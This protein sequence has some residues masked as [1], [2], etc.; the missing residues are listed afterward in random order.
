MAR[1]ALALSALLVLTANAAEPIVPERNLTSIQLKIV[2]VRDE[3][4]LKTKL[5]SRATPE[6]RAEVEALD[7][8][9]FYTVNA[10]GEC[11]VYVMRPETVN[12]RRVLTLG[13]ELLHCVMGNYHQPTSDR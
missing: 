7:L 6:L 9:G 13:H 3:A 2:W 5:M 4:D 10:S 11:V 8:Y 1:I 12:D